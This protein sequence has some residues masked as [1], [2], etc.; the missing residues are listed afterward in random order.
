MGI[1]IRTRNEKLWDYI[2]DHCPEDERPKVPLTRRQKRELADLMIPMITQE[3][4]QM[5]SSPNYEDGEQLWA[6]LKKAF[7]TTGK[8]QYIKLVQ[9][10]RALQYEGSMMEYN[11]A[12]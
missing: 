4:M 12:W 3:A 8:R 5:L 9:E 10:Q 11:N 1:L 2:N 6:A 7:T